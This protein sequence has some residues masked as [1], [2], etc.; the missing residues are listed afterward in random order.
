MC[1]LKVE[2]SLGLRKTD[3]DDDNKYTANDPNE[4]ANKLK[5]M[6]SM[7]KTNKNDAKR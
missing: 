3:E 2:N 1:K 7:G 4:R 5:R 6:F